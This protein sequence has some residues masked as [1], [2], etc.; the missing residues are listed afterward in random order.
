MVHTDLGQWDDAEKAFRG[1]LDAAK[2]SGD[3]VTAC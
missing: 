2:A 3:V 1:A